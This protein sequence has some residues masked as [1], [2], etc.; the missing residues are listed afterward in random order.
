MIK[1]NESVQ[2]ADFDKYYPT[3]LVYTVKGSNYFIGIDTKNNCV[4]YEIK[5][6]GKINT[7]EPVQKKVLTAFHDDL[8]VVYDPETNQQF[9][10][11]IS[12]NESA[13]FIYNIYANGSIK[14]IENLKYTRESKQATAVYANNGFFYFYEQSKR[15]LGWEIRK[16]IKE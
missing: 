1:S 4:I 6:D 10:V 12:T 3:T 14:E 5:S 9:L 15:T 2:K 11:C 8:Q 16:F 13:L 7:D